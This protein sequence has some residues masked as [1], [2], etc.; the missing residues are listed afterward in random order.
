[1]SFALAV[2]HFFRVGNST[3]ILFDYFVKQK[4][5]LLSGGGCSAPVAVSTVLKPFE[6]K[7][8]LTL[9]GGVW[10]LNGTIEIIETD[11]CTVELKK[12]TSETT[13]TS[14]IIV[15]PM[16]SSDIDN[17]KIMDSQN[18]VTCDDCSYEIP[19]KR[20][21]TDDNNT[22][23]NNTKS[24]DGDNNVKTKINLLDDPH[25]HCPV[26]IP[27]GADFMGKCPYLDAQGTSKCPVNAE[28][29]TSEGQH[30]SENITKCPFLSKAKV[31]NQNEIS[32][33]I[34][35]DKNSNTCPN[36]EQKLYV[37]ICS[38]KKTPLWAL[39]QAEHL[40]INLAEKLMKK[41]AS[42]VMSEAQ[43]EIRGN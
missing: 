7:Y 2:L 1:M 22:D 21:K 9:T 34:N 20:R 18:N 3:T 42:E 24:N 43:K 37:G 39:E 30:L 5:M 28:I 36:S 15:C 16:K 6:D 33:E 23:K 38:S 11:K 10:S 8:L 29:L 13:N 4:N 26:T 25:E 35:N 41:G 31:E 19:C 40:G 17:N 27:I 32:N 12:E 14:E